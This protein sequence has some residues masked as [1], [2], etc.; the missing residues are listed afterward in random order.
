[1]SGNARVC[2]TNDIVFPCGG[3]PKGTSPLYIRKDDIIE[4]DY[5]TLMRDKAFWGPDAE[6]FLPER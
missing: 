1:V 6:D 2:L 3:G 5:H 4:A